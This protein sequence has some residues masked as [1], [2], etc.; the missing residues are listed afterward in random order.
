MNSIDHLLEN[1]RRWSE[2]VNKDTPTFFADLANQHNPDYLWIGCSDSRVSTNT[3]IGLDPGEILVHRNVANLVNHTDMNCLSVIQ[4][5]VDVLE[6]DHIIVCG[7]HGCGGVQAA[8]EAKRCGLIDNWVRSIQHTAQRH[9]QFLAECNDQDEKINRLSELN[10][11]EQV[12]NVGESTIV[13]DAW[14]RGQELHVHG[15]IYSLN[16][17]LLRDLEISISDGVSLDKLKSRSLFSNQRQ[18]TEPASKSF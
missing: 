17:G 13:R 18:R 10:V 4:F 11:A 16:D 12:R 2:K 15:W 3:I 1:N 14:E 6:V 5:A 7:H 9:S 8:Y